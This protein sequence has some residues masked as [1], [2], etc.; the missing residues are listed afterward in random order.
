MKQA[1]PPTFLRSVSLLLVGTLWTIGYSFLSLQMLREGYWITAYATMPFIALGVVMAVLGVRRVRGFIKYL[2]EQDNLRM[3]Q[4]Q[5]QF[6]EQLRQDREAHEQLGK[7]VRLM[8]QLDSQDPARI[9]RP[10]E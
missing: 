4:E 1:K 10:A 2:N 8:E 3:E 5:K 9:E 6:G 7:T